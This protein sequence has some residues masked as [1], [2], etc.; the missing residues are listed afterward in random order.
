MNNVDL[1]KLLDEAISFIYKITYNSK[2]KHI[3]VDYPCLK[4]LPCDYMFNCFISNKE[5]D[6]NNKN[7][8]IKFIRSK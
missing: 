4:S 2:I 5:R 6:K 3:D 7:N 8:F 1:E